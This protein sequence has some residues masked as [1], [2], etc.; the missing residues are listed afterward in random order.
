[1]SDPLIPLPARY[2]ALAL[3]VAARRRITAEWATLLRLI[4]TAPQRISLGLS[5]K[6]F[7]PADRDAGQR[8][9]A[10]G[11]VLAGV[12][13]T[14]G[15]KGD[16]WDV[17]SP[18]RPFAVAL[19]RF[20]WL[21]DLLASG[22]P[23]AVEALRLILDWRRQFGRPGSFGW[24]GEVLERRVFNL[25]CGLRSICAGASEAEIT[26]IAAS[27]VAQARALLALDE[28][29]ARAAERCCAAAVAGA[30]VGGR[31]GERLKARALARLARR[32]PAA[33]EDDGGHATRS[34]QA[35]LELLFDLLTLDEVLTQ[36]GEPAP[37]ALMQAIDR[38]YATVRFFTLSDGRLAAFQGGDACA[39]PYVAAAGAQ[40]ELAGRPMPVERAGFHRLQSRSLQLI[41]DATPPAQG[42]WS[43]TACAQPLAVEINAAGRPLIVSGQG[44]SADAAAPPALRMVEAGS[45][46]ALGDLGC[47]APLHG[48]PAQALGPRLVL[49]DA[50]VEAH[51]EESPDAVLLDL[52]H[53]GWIARFGLRHVRRIYLDIGADEVRAEDAFV[54]AG[55]PRKDGRHFAPFAIRFHLHPDVSALAARDGKSVLL[56][57]EGLEH[58]WLLRSD[59]PQMG[60]AMSVQY[61]DA[62]EPRR[63]QQIVM[64]GQARIDQGAKVRWKL[65]SAAPSR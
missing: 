3:V 20:A 15:P 42:A 41:V 61:A 9:I 21:R 32:L 64:R 60:L 8:I 18:T 38:L 58:G 25:A 56:K 36:A 47:G 13:L 53:E 37:E 4:P 40:D 48:F 33:V 39:A 31:A 57:T 45:T 30:A 52:V 16:P 59:A 14:H 2:A 17:Q 46:A 34:P 26:A 7:R 44:W 12:S 11:F 43:V 49:S 19:H 50:M 5:P 29:P 51:R 65:S 23:G 63:S 28:G 55:K 10:G 35:A 54:P 22:R 6:D 27:L 62:R 1:M 24:T